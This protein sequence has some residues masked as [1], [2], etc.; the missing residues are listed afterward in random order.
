MLLTCPEQVHSFHT[1]EQETFQKTPGF[2]AAMKK[3]WLWYGSHGAY[4]F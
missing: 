3:K 1:L 2:F 4:F